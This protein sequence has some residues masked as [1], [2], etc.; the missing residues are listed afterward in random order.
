MF[1]DVFSVLDVISVLK[2][3]LS[4][5]KLKYKIGNIIGKTPEL[6]GATREY[7]YL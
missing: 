2:L 1:L 3:Y 6:A 5:L 4:E 7:K